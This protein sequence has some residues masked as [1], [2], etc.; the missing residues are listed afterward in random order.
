[1]ASASTIR[2]RYTSISPGAR[3]RAAPYHL[4]GF[5]A[6]VRG[7]WHSEATGSSLR[8]VHSLPLWRHCW[9]GLAANETV[10]MDSSCTTK[11][12]EALL[13]TWDRQGQTAPC[14]HRLWPFSCHVPWGL[15]S[16][17]EPCRHFHW[18]GGCSRLSGKARTRLAGVE[19]AVKSVTLALSLRMEEKVGRLDPAWRGVQ[20]ACADSCRLTCID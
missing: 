7:A 5:H 11:R 3:A 13:S 4:A 17:Q 10:T 12:L 20:T 8:R 2:G 14:H 15:R 16:E 19:R 9:S 6:G 1:V 18:P